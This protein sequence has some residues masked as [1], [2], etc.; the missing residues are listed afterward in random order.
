MEPS[1]THVQYSDLMRFTVLH[2]RHHKLSLS[3]CIAKPLLFCSGLGLGDGGVYHKLSWISIYH[4][5]GQP[6]LQPLTT[7]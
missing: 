7:N 6:S 1:T 2:N 5:I 3:S 4:S